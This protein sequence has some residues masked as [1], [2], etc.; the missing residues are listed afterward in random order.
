MLWEI[1]FKDNL[2]RNSP[3]KDHF[4]IEKIARPPM[5]GKMRE[6]TCKL[7]ESEISVED[8]AVIYPKQRPSNIYIEAKKH[9]SE[10][11]STGQGDVDFSSGPVPKTLGRILSLPEYNFS[12]LGSPGRDWEQGFLTAQMRFSASEK[13]QKHETI[14]SHLG[15]TALNSEPLSSVSND[16]IWDKKQASSNPNASASNELHDKEEKTFCSIRDEM[17]SEGSFFLS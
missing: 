11:L 9:L 1:G 15:R 8:E 7:K 14:V 4:F 12:P 13:F 2:G 6:K 10:M 5:G 3:S 17:P 16:S